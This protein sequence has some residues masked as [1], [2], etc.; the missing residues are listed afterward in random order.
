[1]ASPKTKTFAQDRGAAGHDDPDFADARG[2]E[3]LRV[4]Y[5]SSLVF[6]QSRDPEKLGEHIIAT[7]E[8][9]VNSS[10]AR[11]GWCRKIPR[12]WSCLRTATSGSSRTR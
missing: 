1:M 10:V 6:S 8:Q 4:L 2:L 3:K 5:E 12:A 9:L 7:V 11:F